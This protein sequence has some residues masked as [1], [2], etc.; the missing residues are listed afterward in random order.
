V[1]PV[2]VECAG[3]ASR[4]T[5]SHESLPPLGGIA[6]TG[7]CREAGMRSASL[8]PWTPAAVTVPASSLLKLRLFIRLHLLLSHH[9]PES[10]W[11]IR[12]AD[13]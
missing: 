2:S 11:N 6:G 1:P 13:E 4:I 9:K 3:A 10:L 12:L 5:N 7:A 8:I